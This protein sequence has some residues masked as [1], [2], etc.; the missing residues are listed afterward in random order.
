MLVTHEHQ[1]HYYPEALKEFAGYGAR[2]ITNSSITSKLREF[3]VDS[4]ALKP[5]D[6]TDVSVISIK[7]TDSP[8]GALPVPVPENI[9]FVIDNRL[10]ITGDS[11]LPVMHA[12]VAFIPIT[13]PWMKLTEAVEFTKKI[14]PNIAVPVHDGFMK[15][16]FALNLFTK[17]ISEAGIQ[18]KAGN[19]GES[20]EI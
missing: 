13:A 2:I 8:H 9:G 10:F 12:E 11:L 14:N 3:D 6:S 18:V 19:P 7:A 4:E 20:F 17:V 15:Y 5:G 1:D 16:P